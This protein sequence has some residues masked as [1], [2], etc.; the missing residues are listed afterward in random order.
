MPWRSSADKGSG[1]HSTSKENTFSAIVRNMGRFFH[2]QG[3]NSSRAVK[4]RGYAAL[5]NRDAALAMP[6]KYLGKSDG[7]DNILEKNNIE[8]KIHE[9]GYRDHPLARRKKRSTGLRAASERGWACCERSSRQASGT[10]FTTWITA[11]DCAG[12]RERV[13]IQA[14]MPIKGPKALEKGW[15]MK[16]ARRN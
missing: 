1:T 2:R 15:K 9:R 8:N 4:N 3:E 14:R 13:R 10:S 12:G 5:H 7:I 6:R 11:Q 16:Q